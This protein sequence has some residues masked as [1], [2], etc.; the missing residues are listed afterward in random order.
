[1]C[2]ICRLISRKTLLV[3]GLMLS[4]AASTGFA[5]SSYIPDRHAGFFTTALLLFRMVN[6]VGAAAVDVSSMAMVTQ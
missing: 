5:V 3:F 2:A 1:M 4:A 6:G